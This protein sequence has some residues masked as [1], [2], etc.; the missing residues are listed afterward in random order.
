MHFSLDFFPQC[1]Y[2]WRQHRG[3]RA[4]ISDVRENVSMKKAAKK[5]KKAAKKKKK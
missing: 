1:P 4:T 2:T 3:V 5:P